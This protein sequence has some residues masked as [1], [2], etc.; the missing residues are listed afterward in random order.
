MPRSKPKKNAPRQAQS[1]TLRTPLLDDEVFAVAAKM[2]GGA[3]VRVTCADGVERLCVIRNKFR[4]RGKRGNHVGGGSLLLV[5]R[6]SWSGIR[7][8]KLPVCDLLCVYSAEEARTLQHRGLLPHSL[9]AGA[10]ECD[11]AAATDGLDDGLEFADDAP[12]ADLPPGFSDGE[13]DDADAL[14]PAS[15]LAPGETVTAEDI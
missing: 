2:L 5:G 15:A 4:G 10:A 1:H 3:S 7:T 12:L 9:L 13:L 6:R 14:G 11:P 8:G